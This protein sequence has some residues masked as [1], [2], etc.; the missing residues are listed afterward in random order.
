VGDKL[1]SFLKKI[2]CPPTTAI[3][4]TSVKTLANDQQQLQVGEGKGEGRANWEK[5]GIFKVSSSEK[6]YNKVAG[7]Y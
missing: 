7:Y 6:V 3:K 4:A 5:E 1:N 2:F